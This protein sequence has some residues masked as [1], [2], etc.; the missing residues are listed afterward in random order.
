MKKKSILKHQ[1]VTEQNDSEKNISES[2]YINIIII[3]NI[4]ENQIFTAFSLKKIFSK[5]KQ[6]N[7]KEI[8]LSFH[9][10]CNSPELFDNLKGKEYLGAIFYILLFILEEETPK[11]KNIKEVF[12]NDIILLVKKLFL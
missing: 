1:K 8:L 2:D 7:L 6:P 5:L 3:H 10:L 9:H 4:D 11:I 12:L